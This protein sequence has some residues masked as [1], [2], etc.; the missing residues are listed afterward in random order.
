MYGYRCLML[1]PQ[2][3]FALSRELPFTQVIFYT[4]FYTLFNFLHHLHFAYNLY[5]YA[6]VH[7]T[8]TLTFTFY[9]HP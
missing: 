3:R 4:F 8:P 6:Y 5:R 9:P 1:C 2:S 7:I